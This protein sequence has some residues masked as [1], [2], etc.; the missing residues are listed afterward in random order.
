MHKETAP[1]YAYPRWTNVDPNNVIALDDM[2]SVESD[3]IDAEMIEGGVYVRYV[4]R[5]E[6][7][8][9]KPSDN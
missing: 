1:E 6:R 5:W 4:T 8:T 9:A 2:E 7:L 3:E